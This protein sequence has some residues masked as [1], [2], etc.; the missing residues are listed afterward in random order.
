VEENMEAELI[1]AVFEQLQDPLVWVVTAAAGGRRGGLIA[2]FVSKASL[3]PDLPRVVVGIARQHHTWQLIEASHGFAL[4]LFDEN[5]LDW[6]PRFALGSGRDQDKLAD[7]PLM[8][9]PTGSPLLAEALSWLDCRVEA[10]LNTGDRSLFLAE[11]VETGPRRPGQ[12]L[13]L[14]RLLQVLPKSQLEELKALGQRDIGIDRQA[15]LAWRAC[16]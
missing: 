4:H 14:Q 9:G 5:H 3:V 6:L 11:V 2:T 1:E 12:P 16:R 10:D 7:L 8:T 15:I 13:T